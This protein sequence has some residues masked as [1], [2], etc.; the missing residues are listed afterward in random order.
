VSSAAPY[1]HENTQ[2]IRRT[3]TLEAGAF[4]VLLSFGKESNKNK[5]CKKVKINTDAHGYASA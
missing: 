3:V 5:S 1:Q 4:F 2:G